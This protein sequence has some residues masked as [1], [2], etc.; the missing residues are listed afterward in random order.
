MTAPE[1]GRNPSGMLATAA[2]CASSRMAVPI[3]D[4]VE[5]SLCSI[6]PIQSAETNSSSAAE[7]PHTSARRK[8]SA[9]R[10]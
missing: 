5:I 3:R 9:L 7:E 6:S 8:G 4:N 1:R 2:G 10:E